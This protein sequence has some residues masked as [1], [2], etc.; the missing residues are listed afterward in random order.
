MLMIF[1]VLDIQQKTFS[2]KIIAWKVKVAS[3]KLYFKLWECLV[4]YY[5]HQLSCYNSNSWEHEN[6]YWAIIW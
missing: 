1:H 5:K 2:I 3:R 4:G 6:I